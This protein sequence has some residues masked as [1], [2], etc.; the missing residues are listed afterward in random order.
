MHLRAFM[1]VQP[2]SRY[3]FVMP[4]SNVIIIDNRLNYE[5]VWQDTSFDDY[6]VLSHEYIT[7]NGVKTLKIY[8]EKKE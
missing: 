2:D 7:D 5:R 1:R 8:I 4:D 3:L 6:E